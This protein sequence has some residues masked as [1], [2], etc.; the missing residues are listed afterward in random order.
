MR[1]HPNYHNRHGLSIARKQD[2]ELSLLPEV[3]L[4]TEGTSSG[5][6]SLQLYS[7]RKSRTHAWTYYDI[8]DAPSDAEPPGPD[9]D[10]EMVSVDLRD[11]MHVSAGPAGA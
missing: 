7:T 3:R 9:E 4:P 8:A 5:M 11:V 10:V 2:R 1:A 6:P